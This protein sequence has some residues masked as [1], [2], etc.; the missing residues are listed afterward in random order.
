MDH[1][2][3]ARVQFATSLM[4]HIVFAV[5]GIGMPLLML[6][7]E[8]AWLRTG[9]AQFL[10]LAKRWAR[11]AGILFAVGAVSGTVISFELGLLWPKFMQFAG[12]II[13]MPFSME[14]FAFFI[15]AI[16]LALYLFGWDRL[17][18]R[19]HFL[20]ALPVAISGALSGIFVV[21]AN[22]WMNSP[23]G[24][25][26]VAGQVRDVDPIAAILN[27]FWAT[28]ATH[29]LIAAYVT[30]GF[31]VAAAHAVAL[32]RDRRDA[33]ARRGFAIAF[34]VAA[35]LSPFQF[36]SGDANARTVAALQ[37]PKLAAMEALFH[38]TRCAPEMLGGI[39]DVAH[40]SV[41]YGIGVPC[42]LSVLAKLNPHAV[43]AG[44]D[45]FPTRD[46]PNTLVVHLAFQIMVAVGTGLVLL[47]MWGFVV[48][49]RTRQTPTNPWLL[50][51]TI[52]AGGL[53]VVAI[54]AGWIVTEV[55]RQPWA[56]YHVFTTAQSLTAASNTIIPSFVVF[57]GI[58]VLL[59]AVL[60]WLLVRLA[61]SPLP[62]QPHSEGR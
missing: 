21:D 46:R 43:I 11:A 42:G 61:T 20:T 12:A 4:F 50:R 29:M 28:E 59:S 44:L 32:L 34:A 39:P 16:F 24:F 53:S 9:D 45:A 52:A 8:G 58:Y 27:P 47:G 60:I 22:A 5:Y 23:T 25:H 18:P 62:D 19:A 33:Y 30:V 56:V 37:P 15:E 10:D 14:A 54:E 6:I 55:G 49:W 31:G 7:A 38:T 17:S 36:I 57:S 41:R 26:M 35:L 40:Q 48:A 51:A 2:F 3:A 13:G 1:L